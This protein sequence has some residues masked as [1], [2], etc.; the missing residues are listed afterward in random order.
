MR[1]RL[2][3]ILATFLAAD[4]GADEPIF[5]VVEL[6]APGRT[7]AA[8]FADLDGDGRSDVYVISLSGIPPRARREP[9]EG[10]GPALRPDRLLRRSVPAADLP[11][12]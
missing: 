3:A 12:A 4:A 11:R 10:A 8:G 9:S 7:A 5:R 2:L 6:P 1:G